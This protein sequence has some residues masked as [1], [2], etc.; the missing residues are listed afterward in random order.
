MTEEQ[1]LRLREI[2]NETL[3][4]RDAFSGRTHSDHHRFVE[5]LIEREKRKQ[6]RRE[7]IRQQVIGWGVIS[8]LSGFGVLVYNAFVEF[9]K[10]AS[11]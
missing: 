1:I 9:I 2:I 7:R 4:E 6:E 11:H 3:D 10:R 5:E 8:A